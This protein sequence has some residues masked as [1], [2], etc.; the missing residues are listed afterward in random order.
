MQNLQGTVADKEIVDTRLRFEK[1][2]RANA[3]SIRNFEGEFYGGRIEGSAS[4]GLGAGRGYAFN[5][6]AA[7]V[8]FERLLRE[9]FRL[10]HNITG[11]LL[12]GTLDLRAKGPDAKTVEASGYIYVTEAKLY[13]LPLVVRLL[14][15]LRLAPPD[16]TA[17]QKARVLYFLRD[18]RLILG[19]VRLEGRAMNLYGAGTMEAD[20]RL[21]L[22]FMTGKKNDDPLIPALSELT[23]GIRKQI[24]VVL[25]T[26]TLAEPQ[27]KTRTLSAVTA[28]LRELIALVREQRGRQG[29]AGAPG[30]A[31]SERS[32]VAAV[33]GSW[34]PASCNRGNHAASIRVRRSSERARA[35]AHGEVPPV[36]PARNAADR[37]TLHP[38]RPVRL[39]DRTQASQTTGV[40]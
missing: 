22:A 11:G 2:E 8:D 10:E 14:N 13:E 23:E 18:K 5:L 17:F 1:P 36:P 25:V 31:P 6:S 38:G 37:R 3:V 35:G 7:D 33:N 4:I 32:A 19:D 34:W 12:R 24:V 15:A 27:V 28:P 30:Q 29:R 39:L 9:G 26:G 40:P 21:N 20:G 16:R